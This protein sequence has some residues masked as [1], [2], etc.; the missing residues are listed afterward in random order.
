MIWGANKVQF[1][2]VAARL[3]I[4]DI[5][6]D[7]SLVCEELAEKV[8]A[9]PKALYRYMRA[10]S[11]LGLFK[12]NEDGT[13]GLTPLSELLMTDAQGSQKE[14]AILNGE[15]WAW[16][17]WGSL[18]QSIKTGIPAIELEFGMGLYEYF[19]EN[20]DVGARY[21][22]WMSGVTAG[23]GPL[24]ADIYDFEEVGNVIDVAGG[25]GALL[26]AILNKHPS[27]HA[28][29]AEQPSVLGRAKN[30]L[31]S[32]GVYD[33]CELISTDILESIP[34][35]GDLYILKRVIQAFDDFA[36]GKIL[37]NCRRAMKEDSRILI[38]DMVVPSDGN[39]HPSKAFDVTMLLIGGVLRTVD[40]YQ[41]LFDKAGVALVDTVQTEEAITILV[42]TPG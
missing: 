5:L 30:F 12:E 24:I 26:A 16:R 34:L 25:H 6:K 19:F 13:F 7:Q 31:E 27:I 32:E 10:A 18:L 42:C 4:A 9:H 22:S 29:L 21:D 15:E 1:V 11:C 35:G 38:A 2:H 17:A 3:G 28:V 37:S 8:N 40:E 33:R 14:S 41:E 39:P 20:P 23:E 36:A